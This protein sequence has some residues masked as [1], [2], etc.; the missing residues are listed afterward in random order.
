MGAEGGKRAVDDLSLISTRSKIP[1]FANSTA[2]ANRLYAVLHSL[3]SR[4]HTKS[5]LQPGTSTGKWRWGWHWS[6]RLPNSQYAA[7]I[8]PAEVYGVFRLKGKFWALNRRHAVL[9]LVHDERRLMTPSGSKGTA[10]SFS[11][12]RDIPYSR[13]SE[14][15]GMNAY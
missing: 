8:D 13:C 5:H 4:Q 7:C 12:G 1:K 6:L 2:T 10:E 3:L 15:D 14:F 11:T 9:D